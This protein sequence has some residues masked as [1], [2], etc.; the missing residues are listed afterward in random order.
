MSE[1]DKADRIADAL[2]QLGV[3]LDD[4]SRT[5]RF[6]YAKGGSGVR[7]PDSHDYSRASSDDF[8]L[9]VDEIEQINAL[10]GRRLAAKKGRE[11]DKADSLQ[12][13]LRALG[14]E[15]DDKRRVWYVRYHEGGRT[16]SSF[17]VRGW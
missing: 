11:F 17:N 5:W 10:L 9:T 15:V 14:V 2:F 12:A 13:E 3:D 7:S 16:A 6:V 4:R 8:V 1:Y